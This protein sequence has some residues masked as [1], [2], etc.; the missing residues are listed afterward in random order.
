MHL[1]AISSNDGNR[2]VP[3]CS[4]PDWRQMR[5]LGPLTRRAKPRSSWSRA[6]TD[7]QS[8]ILGD[9]HNIQQM[10]ILFHCLMA[11]TLSHTTAHHIPWLR[12][13]ILFCLD[14]GTNTLHTNSRHSRI[15]TSACLSRCLHVHYEKKTT[16][17][18][19]CSDF[20]RR[21]HILIDYMQ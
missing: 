21:L 10:F 14:V 19:I 17:S 7:C 16:I 15:S 5:I 4:R 18:S 13:P 12:L 2:L 9:C 11:G 8:F 20:H 6:I 3:T 1:H